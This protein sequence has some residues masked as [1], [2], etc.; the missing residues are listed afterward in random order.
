MFQTTKADSRSGFT[1]TDWDDSATQRWWLVC[2]LETAN[3]GSSD[4][5]H[6][7]DGDEGWYPW[8]IKSHP[9]KV[10]KKTCTVRGGVG[11]KTLEI[12]DGLRVTMTSLKNIIQQKG[13]LHHKTCCKSHCVV[14]VIIIEVWRQKTAKDTSLHIPC[15]NVGWQ[16]EI[17]VR[18]WSNRQRVDRNLKKERKWG[19]VRGIWSRQQNGWKTK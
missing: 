5:R 17:F 19:D 16:E 2:R 9:E 11:T 15:N 13:S 10:N 8:Y 12:W 6:V 7:S 18:C 3:L 4:R 14:N 1:S